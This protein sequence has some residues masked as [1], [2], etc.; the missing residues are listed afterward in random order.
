MLTLSTETAAVDI[1]DRIHFRQKYYKE[2][3]GHS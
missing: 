2:I 1:S 3:E